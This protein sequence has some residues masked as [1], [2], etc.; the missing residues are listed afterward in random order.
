MENGTARTVVLLISFHLTYFRQCAAVST[1]RSLIIDPII[2][3]VS[4]HNYSLKKPPQKLLLFPTPFS[5]SNSSTYSCQGHLPGAVTFR[6]P[7]I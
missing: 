3:K 7:M 4:G 1:Q 6:P 2:C 5:N